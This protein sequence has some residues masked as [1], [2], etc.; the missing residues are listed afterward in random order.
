MADY[1]IFQCKGGDVMQQFVRM[2]GLSAIGIILLTGCGGPSPIDGLVDFVKDDPAAKR[3]LKGWP[4]P[5]G[6]EMTGS[7]SFQRTRS[8]SANGEVIRFGEIHFSGL[9]GNLGQSAV[10][11]FYRTALTEQGYE[12]TGGE[13]GLKFRG[14]KWSGEVTVSAEVPPVVNV[15]AEQS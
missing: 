5:E 4:L 6:F 10:L 3:F 15:D 8:V 13:D 14:E 2:I 11:E 7:P 9:A 1:F 12:V